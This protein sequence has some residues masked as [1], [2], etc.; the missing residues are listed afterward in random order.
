VVKSDGFG[1]VVERRMK[2]G[3]VRRRYPK[4]ITCLC[5]TGQ[6]TLQ[7]QWMCINAPMS[8]MA[9][10]VQHLGGQYKQGKRDARPPP[11]G[12]GGQMHA[13][14]VQPLL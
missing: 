3:G 7:E 5:S 8:E 12:N 6:I 11:S 13:V 9:G 1:F 14:L 2:R 10:P 4:H